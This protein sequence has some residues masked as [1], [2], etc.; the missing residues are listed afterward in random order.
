MTFE[1][2]QKLVLQTAIGLAETNK[3]LAETNKS[4]T[5]IKAIAE[6]NAR[7]IQAKA[8]KLDEKFD[9]KLAYFFALDCIKL[10]VFTTQKALQCKAF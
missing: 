6:S 1:H 8:N 7:A 5:R 10:F 4:L 9:Q 2:L 3:S